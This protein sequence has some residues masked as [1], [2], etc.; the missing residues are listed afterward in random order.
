IDMNFKINEMFRLFA[1]EDSQKLISQIN[2]RIKEKNLSKTNEQ[3]FI[4]FRNQYNQN[5]NPIDLYILISYSYNY[6]IRFNNNLKFNNPFGKNRSY[7]SNNMK[8]NLVNFSNKLK[9][10]N[11][12]FIDSYFQDIDLSFLDKEALVYL[13]PPYIITTGSYNDGN[14]GFQNWGIS[15]EKQMYNL[16][17]TLT[18]RGIRYALSNVLHHKNIEN[19]LLQKF[20][21]EN[22]VQVHHLNHSYH[23]SSYNTTRAQSD[24]VLITNY[25]KD[26]FKLLD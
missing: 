23:N 24:E 17:K 15:Q 2:R 7:F 20:I 9:S 3:S 1:K 25:D 21:D 5:P 6:Q 22:N 4:K 19:K 13:D 16:M 14:R 18:D 10:L 26:T 11:H 12:E 8:N